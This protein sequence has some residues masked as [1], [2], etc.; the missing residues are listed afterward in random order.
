MDPTVSL[1]SGVTPVLQCGTYEL[2][3]L[4]VCCVVL[5]ACK[6]RISIYK[7]PIEQMSIFKIGKAEEPIEV[8]STHAE[9]CV[10][11]PSASDGRSRRKKMA[12]VKLIIHKIGE[13]H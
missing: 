1:S 10:Q 2:T 7:W 12:E 11:A 5:R 9:R 6:I 13:L 4:Y 3:R 8:C